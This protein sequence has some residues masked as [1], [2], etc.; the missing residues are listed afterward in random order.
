MHPW[1]QPLVTSSQHKSKMADDV[2]LSFCQLLITIITGI[3]CLYV[4]K[5]V[6]KLSLRINAYN[7]QAKML[8]SEYI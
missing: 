8:Y 1:I 6:L 4:P 2:S 3:P 7:I 5:T